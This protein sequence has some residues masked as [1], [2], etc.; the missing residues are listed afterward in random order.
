MFLTQYYLDCLSQASYMIADERT[1]RAVVV[2]PRRDVSEYLTDAAAHGLAVVGV[3]ASSTRTSTPTSWPATWRW[4]T[5]PAPG[6]ATGDARRPSTRSVSS[7]RASGSLGDVT[8]EILETPG[9]TPE[10]ISVHVHE[11]ADDTVPYG[12]LTGDALLRHRGFEDVSDVLGGY[13]AWSL[14]AA[15]SSSSPPWPYSAGFRWAP[16]S[17]PRSS[18]SR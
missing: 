15:G 8:L 7:P 14:S 6:S 3:I 2:A 10:S 9:H 13:A 16:R 18:S 17:A 12:V 5:R 4:R 11:H 1:G